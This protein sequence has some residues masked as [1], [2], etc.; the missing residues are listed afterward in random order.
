MHL[1]MHFLDAGIGDI[2]LIKVSSILPAGTQVVELP[3]FLQEKW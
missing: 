1:I 2:N 3:E